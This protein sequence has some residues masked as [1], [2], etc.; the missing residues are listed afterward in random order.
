MRGDTH[1]EVLTDALNEWNVHMHVPNYYRDRLRHEPSNIFPAVVAVPKL[2]TSEISSE[3]TDFSAQLEALGVSRQHFDWNSR[4]PC[5]T[6]A[7]RIH[8]QSP[9]ATS[10]SR[11]SRNF[12]L[13]KNEI[14]R[15]GCDMAESSSVSAHV[16]YTSGTTGVPKG[17]SLSHAIVSKHAIGTAIEMRLSV[18]DLHVVSLHGV[19]FVAMS[20]HVPPER[21]VRKIS[22]VDFSAYVA[23]Y[24]PIK[25]QK[26]ATYYLRQSYTRKP[27]QVWGSLP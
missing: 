11:G 2:E 14:H 6:E 26:R 12:M 20:I 23:R 7:G 22:V 13:N 5:L 8:T 1:S 25:S 27:G 16:Y 19:C 4:F 9:S 10:T 15:V 17:V 18:A 21:A 3:L 24:L